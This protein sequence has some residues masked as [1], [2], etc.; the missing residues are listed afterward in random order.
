[1]N[2]ETLA[3]EVVQRSTCEKFLD[4]SKEI[5]VNPCCRYA[6]IAA[7]CR[8]WAGY[9]IGFYMPSFFGNN[10]KDYKK[11]YSIGNAFVVSLF[12][13]TSAVGGGW[14]S[15]RFEN[16]GNFMSKAW[17]CIIGTAG[18]IPTI[19]L[20]TLVQ[21]NF[22][23]SLTGLGLEYLMAECWIGP[24]ITMVVNTISPEN[25][26]F[27]VSAFLFFSTVS[28]TISAAALGALLETYGAKGDSKANPPI[29]AKP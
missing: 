22:W 11:Q 5:F 20:C 24:V 27:A 1:M 14:L 15:D 17:V 13:F 12:G 28:G 26:G 2:S 25:K 29:E 4:A 18:G 3:Q 7:V 21:N 9:A 23:A 10:Y 8:F 19:M 6:T 16:R